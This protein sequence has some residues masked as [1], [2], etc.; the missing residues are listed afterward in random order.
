MRYAVGCDHAGFPLKEPLIEELRAQGHEVLDMG[1]D[2]LES[3]DYP[4]FA[5]RVARAIQSGEAD[6]GLLVC[7]T[8]LGMGISANKFR[9]IR[10]AIVS[11]EY[12]ARMAR[13]H[14]NCNVLCVGARV[15]GP[16]AAVDV[17]R[18]WNAETYEGGRHQ[19]R[20]DMIGEFETV[21]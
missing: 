4:L 6:A 21:C 3:V 16:G 10:A 5:S 14:T 9:G 20:V 17:L 7:G 15:L 2:G 1:T 12:S 13:R 8:G 18:A 11:D 19:R